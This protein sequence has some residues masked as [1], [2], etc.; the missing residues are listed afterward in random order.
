M[1]DACQALIPLDNCAQIHMKYD[2]EDE[3]IP[4][5]PCSKLL[6]H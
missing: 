4:T 6:R 1:T 3:P 2:M 5:V